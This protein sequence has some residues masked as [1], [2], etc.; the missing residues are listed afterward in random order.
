[1]LMEDPSY[2]KMLQM[3]SSY[4]GVFGE[5]WGEGSLTI[6]FILIVSVYVIVFFSSFECEYYAYFEYVSWYGV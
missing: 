2:F 3:F 6:I 1:M 4:L 5:L